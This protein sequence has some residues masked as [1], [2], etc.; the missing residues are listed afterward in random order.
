[1][2]LNSFIKIYFFFG[3]HCNLVHVSLNICVWLGKLA[4]SNVIS[5]LKYMKFNSVFW[6]KSTIFVHSSHCCRL[7]FEIPIDSMVI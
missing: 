3:N 7:G 2:L 1:M 4:Q 5:A 6:Y